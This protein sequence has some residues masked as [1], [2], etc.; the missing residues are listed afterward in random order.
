MSLCCL[1]FGSRKSSPSEKQHRTEEKRRSSLSPSIQQ[2]FLIHDQS[3]EETSFIHDQ[4][5]GDDSPSKNAHYGTP[6]KSESHSSLY[7]QQTPTQVSH[8]IA[9][10]LQTPSSPSNNGDY[11][12]AIPEEKKKEIEVICKNYNKFY[13]PGNTSIKTTP[14]KKA[15]A[16]K[17]EQKRLTALNHRF[18]KIIGLLEFSH[19][20]NFTLLTSDEQKEFVDKVLSRI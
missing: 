5:V 3:T 2:P 9:A 15:A 4:P 6:Q 10:P 11:S 7:F 17:F 14:S 8:T 19:E 1:C 18:Q 12:F 16:E 13:R 20:P